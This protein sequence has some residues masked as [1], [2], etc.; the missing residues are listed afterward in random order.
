[1]SL[2]PMDDGTSFPNK[3]NGPSRHLSL[4]DHALVHLYGVACLY[5]WKDVGDYA[6]LVYER[7]GSVEEVQGCARHLVVF[8]GYGPCLAAMTALKKAKAIPH[9]TPGK[10][11]GDPGNAFG[12]VYQG[13]E[14][15]VRD[16]VYDADPVL[17]S[18]IQSHLYGDVYSSPGLTM[19]Q[20]QYLTIMGLVKSHMM[21][22]I[23]GHAFAALRFGATEDA[24]KEVVDIAAFLMT[25][26]SSSE[27]TDIF[28][29]AKRTIDMA[30]I[31]YKRGS[32]TQNA[33]PPALVVD[34]SSIRIPMRNS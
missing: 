31:K 33:D 3:V 4:V 21:E 25:Q 24:L 6:S 17:E 29:K 8:C 2:E 28:R 9:D 19:L 34:Q 23:Y 18:W 14:G 26:S 15:A 32:S 10:V 11:G 5:R 20:K 12:I 22:Q 27:E 16:K 13:V 30:V 7:G 1:M